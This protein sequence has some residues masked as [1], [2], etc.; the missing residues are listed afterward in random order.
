[1]QRISGPPRRHSQL[2]RTNR[3]ADFYLVINKFES[4][5]GM[6]YLRTRS[7]RYINS[8]LLTYFN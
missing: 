5:I 8:L 7:T 1:M 2:W 6:H 4:R 3:T